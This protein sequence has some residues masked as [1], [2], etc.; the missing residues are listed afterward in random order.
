MRKTLYL[1][2]YDIVCNK[3]RNKVFKR[4]ISQAYAL[5]YSV[6]LLL[7]YL[8]NTKCLMEE[9]NEFIEPTE[10]KLFCVTVNSQGFCFQR[11]PQDNAVEL[12]HEHALLNQLLGGWT[13]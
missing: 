11:Q 5:H 8:D 3:R 7:D 9:L 12:I 4:L 2:S 13:V 10:D 6:F 1:V